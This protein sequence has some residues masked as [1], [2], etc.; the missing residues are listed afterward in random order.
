MDELDQKILEEL[1]NTGIQ[2]SEAL[3][4][5]MG[6]GDR[7]VRRRLSQ[8]KKTGVFRLVPIP[9]LVLLGHRAWARI[10]IKAY[11]QHLKDV[12]TSLV[13]YPAIYSVATSFGRFDLIIDVQLDTFE[14]LAHFTNAELSGISGIQKTESMILMSPRKYYSYL[15]PEPKFNEKCKYCNNTIVRKSDIDAVDR[16]IINVIMQSGLF[17][18]NDLKSKLNISEGTIRKR[19]KEMRDNEAFKLEVIPDPSISGNEISATIGINIDKH[20]AHEIIDKIID[21]PEVYLASTSLGRFNIILAMQFSNME[22]FTKFINEKLSN[23]S[24]ISEVE[25]FVHTKS[26]KFHNIQLNLD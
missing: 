7:T 23:M 18:F 14:T 4:S 8:M 1:R 11:P 12:T 26:L 3:S 21:Y 2:S 9:N 19:I 13:N 20:S 24:G 22:S 25:S 16:K 6:V 10:G 15:W 17:S 5:I